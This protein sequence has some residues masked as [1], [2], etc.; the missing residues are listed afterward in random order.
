MDVFAAL[1]EPTRRSIIE[2][3]ATRGALSASE[4]GQHFPISAPAVSQHLKVLREANV[5]AVERQAQ[6]RI[7]RINPAAIREMESWAQQMR[8]QWNQRFDALDA[9]LEAEQATDNSSDEQPT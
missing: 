1:A 8:R 4:I 5:V 2:M 7:Y 6:W 9:L 3:L